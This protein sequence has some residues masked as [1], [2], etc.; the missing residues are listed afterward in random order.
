MKIKKAPALQSSMSNKILKKSLRR[1]DSAH[2]ILRLSHSVSLLKIAMIKG[3]KVPRFISVKP[4]NKP[5]VK[6]C[7]SFANL[8]AVVNKKFAKAGQ[9]LALSELCRV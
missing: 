5:A 7:N 4:Q 9:D 3:C 8:A 1:Y 2:F 6:S